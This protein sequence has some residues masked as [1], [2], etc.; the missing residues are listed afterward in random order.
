MNPCPKSMS[1]RFYDHSLLLCN[2]TRHSK[3]RP[4]SYHCRSCDTIMDE[5]RFHERDRTCDTRDQRPFVLRGVA[6][7]HPT[8]RVSVAAS[9]RLKDAELRQ[10]LHSYSRQ[11][12][13]VWSCLRMFHTP[14]G[15]RRSAHPPPVESNA[16]PIFNEL[17]FFKWVRNSAIYGYVPR[18]D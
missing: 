13:R 17:Y 9:K 11:L 10:P 12:S 1:R 14:P 4:A 8:H 5:Q 16:P 3:R 7:G 15:S 6:D 2:D 18:R